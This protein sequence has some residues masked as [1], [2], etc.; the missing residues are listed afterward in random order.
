MKLYSTNNKNN[1]VDLKEAVFKSLPEDKGLYMPTTIP[2]LSDGFLKNLP[3]YSFQA[4]AFEVA[5]QLIGAYIPDEDVYDIIEKSI[6]FSAPVVHLNEQISVLELFHG[7]SL[8]F[9][10][11]GARFMAQLMSYLRDENE[12]KITILVAT[13]GDTGGAVAAG[14][15][16]TEGIE[17]FILY[18]SGKVSEIQEKQLTTLEGNIRAFEVQGTFD[19]CQALVKSAFLD[20]DLNKAYNLSSANSINIARLIPQSFYYFE[21]FK[22]LAQDEI[23]NTFCVPSGNFGNLTAGLMAKKMG[24]PVHQFIAATNIND[25]VPKYLSTNLFEPHPSY[26]TISNAMDVGNPSNFVRM[27]DLYSSTWNDMKKDVIGFAIDDAATA[28]AIREVHQQFAYFIDPHAA[29]GYCAAKYYLADRANTRVVVLGTAHPAKFL[30]VMNDALNEQVPIPEILATLINKEK[31]A[32]S[33]TSSFEDF[34][35]CLLDLA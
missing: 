18:P 29:V 31:K 27:L 4:I 19:D 8:A 7:P 35:L 9:K 26:T 22:Q 21:A 13:S 1:I 28:N 30:D 33:I 5:R 2:K 3:K 32:T 10:D 34:K 16:N 23:K 12:R 6:T 14:F 11:F 25:V 20:K 24:L 15:H 17:V